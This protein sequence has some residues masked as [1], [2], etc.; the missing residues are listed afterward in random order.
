MPDSGGSFSM[1]V[2]PDLAWDG[3]CLGQTPSFLS[4]LSVTELSS[5]SQAG[6][7]LTV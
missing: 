1:S 7:H 4:R 5:L 6:F 3:V 2:P